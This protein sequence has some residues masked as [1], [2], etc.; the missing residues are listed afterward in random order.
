MRR[1]LAATVAPLVAA[2]VLLTGCGG[3]GASSIVL[4]NGQ[5]AETTRLLTNAFERQTGIRVNLHTGD[6]LVVATQIL[7]EGH[8]SPADVVLT[9]NS[10]ELV[11]L[12][13][14]GL[15]AQLPRSVLSQVS[16]AYESPR[17][18]WVG[19]ALR[20][21][22]LVYDPKLVARPRLPRSI[23]DLAQPR[24]KG[25]VA[26]APTD[27]DFPPIVAAV[28]ARVGE[29]RAAAW[30]QGLKRNA[31]TYQDEEAVA[32]AVNRG[33]VACGIINH[34]YWYRLR[35]ELGAKATRSAL[36]FFPK[37]D[38]GSIVNVSGVGVLAT[39]KHRDAALRFVE[40]MVGPAAQRILA[41]SDDFEY[42]ARI[43]AAANKAL[44]P[45]AQTPHATTPVAKLGN[46][47]AAARLIRE[48][49]LI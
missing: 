34:Y 4:Y 38:V 20:I 46:G 22:A 29:Q 14:H 49:G 36:Y 8:A 17:G 41:Q 25:K 39:S 5:H 12:E 3:G 30:L 15:L 16:A 28:I 42:P 32:A 2:L 13:Q 47:T 31:Q 9:E 40:F 26:L 11:T 1:P 48:T 23:L 45:F 35:L 27:S 37:G 18:K 43:G 44:T 33:A 6:S 21:S 24:W 7:Q 19:M 10:P